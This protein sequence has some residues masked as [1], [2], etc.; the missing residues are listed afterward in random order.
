MKSYR[1]VCGVSYPRPN[2]RATYVF[3]LLALLYR[4]PVSRSSCTNQ[5][6]LLVP[7][8]TCII[9]QTLLQ[10]K[11]NGFNLKLLK[12]VIL[13]CFTFYSRRLFDTVYFNVDYDGTTNILP[14]TR[15]WTVFRSW[16]Y[17][18]FHANGTS[19]SGSRILHARRHLVRVDL[20]HGDRRLDTFLHI[21][22]VYAETP[23]GL[24]R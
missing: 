20:L 22:L 3:I 10:R 5:S 13:C 24:L 2:C 15:N 11:F 9:L 12:Y 17:R 14:G 1:K 21:R 18:S 19:I 23:L 8:N 6:R 7:F 16:S 4:A